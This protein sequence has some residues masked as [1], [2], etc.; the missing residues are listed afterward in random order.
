MENVKTVDETTEVNKDFLKDEKNEKENNFNPNK[1]AQKPAS[2]KFQHFE[3]FTKKALEN[4]SSQANKKEPIKENKI[5]NMDIIKH[6][7]YLTNFS[8]LKSFPTIQPRYKHTNTKDN[9]NK[10]LN[11]WTNTRAKLSN[12][13]KDKNRSKISLDIRNRN[14]RRKKLNEKIEEKNFKSS[15]KIIK[16]KSKTPNQTYI[17]NKN[18]ESTDTNYTINK[19]RNQKN[20]LIP[21]TQS[22]SQNVEGY[23]GRKDLNGVPYTFEPIMLFNN[24]YS[25]KSEKKRHEIILDEFTRLRQYIERQ[26]INKLKFIKEFLKKYYIEYEKY[27]DDQLSSLCDFICYHDKIAISSILKP[28]LNMK[29][30]ISELVENID[31]TNEM[32][33]IKKNNKDK[34]NEIKEEEETFDVERQRS[35]KIY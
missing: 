34:D 23:L 6:K 19:S 10:S 9:R 5:Y 13:N 3:N 30:M 24:D 21:K 29:D 26:P 14:M 22:N 32:L 7:T 25:N 11:T 12:I 4:N 18:N 27:T 2:L 35:Q 17:A 31:K 8:S 33:G 16:L 15:Y 1:S 28:Y 20:I